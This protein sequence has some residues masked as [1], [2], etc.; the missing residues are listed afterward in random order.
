MMKSDT[1][2]TSELVTCIGSRGVKQEFAVSLTSGTVEVWQERK[3]KLHRIKCIDH[4]HRD[5]IH[6]CCYSRDGRALVTGSFDATLKVASVSDESEYKVSQ[7]LTGHTELVTCCG[8]GQNT[9]VSGFDDKTVRL[10]DLNT[11]QRK[12]IVRCGNLM[13]GCDISADE[14]LVV[15]GMYN[16]GCALIDTRSCKSVHHR[17]IDDARRCQ[18]SSDMTTVTQTAE[19]GLYIM[20]FS[21]RDVFV[22]VIN[23]RGLYCK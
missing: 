6:D 3:G 9:V 11:G 15:F 16:K 10:W 23:P 17:D 13:C 5:V 1:I 12:A 21:L 18:F 2:E 20:D 7:T 19:S 8:A 4:L 22:Q 14:K